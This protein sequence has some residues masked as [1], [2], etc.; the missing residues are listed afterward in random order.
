MIKTIIQI[1]YETASFK[2]T[3]EYSPSK[4]AFD[5]L[6]DL[7]SAEDTC[8]VCL[9]NEDVIDYLIKPLK[10]ILQIKKN[11]NQSLASI[12]SASSSTATNCFIYEES[13]MLILANV[14]SK[15]ASTQCGYFQLLYND[16]KQN[17]SPIL[18][19]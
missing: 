5:L 15:L 7:C 12:S 10:A 9:C 13:C 18:N 1:I 2:T 17:F 6:Q 16:S 19:K 14:L 11:Q 3:N 4:Y 8:E